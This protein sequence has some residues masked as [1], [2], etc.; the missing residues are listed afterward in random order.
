VRTLWVIC[1]YSKTHRRGL[2]MG[3]LGWGLPPPRRSRVGGGSIDES[4]A[5]KARAQADHRDEVGA[6]TRAEFVCFDIDVTVAKVRA[7]GQHHHHVRCPRISLD[8][9][10]RSGSHRT[11]GLLERSLVHGSAYD[12]HLIHD[13][14]ERC[15]YVLAP[16]RNSRHLCQAMHRTTAAVDDALLQGR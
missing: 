7:Q 11:T 2:S 1:D 4:T 10:T 6:L 12:A 3:D 5:F 13:V 14:C 8:D 9:A 16:P 15:W